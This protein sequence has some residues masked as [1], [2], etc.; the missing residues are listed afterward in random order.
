M[1]DI[2]HKHAGH[3]ITIEG[4][5]F[6]ANDA[7]QW[8]LTEIWQTLKLPKGKQPKRFVERKEAQ[9]LEQAGKIGSLNRGRAGSQTL[10]AKQAVI[11]YAA[12]VS[13]EFEDMV[14]EAFE[15]I[16]ELPEVMSAVT[17]QMRAM[18]YQHS[19]TLL[20]R[21]KDNRRE[22]FRAMRRGP[23]RPLTA[24]QKERQRYARMARSEADK[25]RRAGREYVG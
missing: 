20:E 9:R 17:D 23:K 10:A 21:E 12:W 5:P 3:L 15:A 16:L 6:M 25:A 14:F 22:A 18:G 7:G 2:K 13:P 11:R 1:I 19:A 4:K 8:D 24:E